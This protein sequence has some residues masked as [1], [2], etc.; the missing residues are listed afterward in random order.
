MIERRYIA[1]VVHQDEMVAVRIE[2]V[3]LETLAMIDKRP[4]PAEFLDEYTVSQAL[5]GKEIALRIGKPQMQVWIV[6]DHRL[7][8]GRR[9]DAF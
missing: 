9:L 3:A 1:P 4:V 8:G 5:R 2:P 7:F 6:D